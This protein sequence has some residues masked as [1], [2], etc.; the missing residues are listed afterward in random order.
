M[1]SLRARG[2]GTKKGIES[3]I[4]TST[5]VTMFGF[6]EKKDGRNSAPP[7]SLPSNASDG[8]EKWSSSQFKVAI[9]HDTKLAMIMT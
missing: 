6:R 4:E 7:F 2:G 3:D 8:S 1:K 9:A 5:I